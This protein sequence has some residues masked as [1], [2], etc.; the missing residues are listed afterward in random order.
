METEKVYITRD[1]DSSWIWVWRKP[2][3]GN[4]SPDN[5][6]KKGG[7]VNWQ[8]PDHNLEGT[9]AY[10]FSDF[11]TKFGITIHEKTKKCVHLPISLLENEDYKIFSN[12]SKR[13]K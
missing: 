4:W 8:R 7:F 13:K 11:K 2:S 6:G 3:K 9:Q 1:E 5:M 12:D 10:L